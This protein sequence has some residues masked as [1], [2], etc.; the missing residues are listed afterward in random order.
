MEEE[1][2]ESNAH[3]RVEEHVE[4]S[5]TIPVGAVAGDAEKKEAHLIDRGVGEEAAETH[6]VEGTKA[7][8]K[9]RSHY[10]DVKGECAELFDG[11]KPDAKKLHQRTKHG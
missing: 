9:K 5:G 10:G 7:S 8:S 6:F 11:R 4:K 2:E 1:N 3:E